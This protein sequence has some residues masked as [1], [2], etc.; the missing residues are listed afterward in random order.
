MGFFHKEGGGGSEAIPK[1]LGQ[2][3]CINICVILGRKRGGGLTKSKRFGA[4]CHKIFGE[5]GSTKLPK[6]FQKLGH[7]KSFKILGEGGSDLILE[8]NQIKAFFSDAPLHR[9]G[10]AINGASTWS[11]NDTC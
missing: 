1:F 7:P 2:F 9:K 6:K 10:F 3:L 11:F 8:E 5:L 4:H